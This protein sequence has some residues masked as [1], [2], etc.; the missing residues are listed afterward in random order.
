MAVRD[1]V[2]SSVERALERVLEAGYLRKWMVLGV[3]IGIVAGLG[4]VG[5][6]LAIRLC[7]WLL[8]DVVG[9]YVPPSAVGEG[10]GYAS[11]FARPW[12]VP[13]VVGFGG[14]IS[15]V[16]VT[17]FAPEA[18]GHGTDAAIDAVHRNPRGMRA[19][20]S[21]VKLVASAVTIGSGGSAGREGPTAQ[22]S[23][24]FASML[25]RRLDLT[26]TDAR[27]AVT[28]GIGS[29][30][31]AIF[32]APLGGA[33]LGAE[34]LYRD[35]LEA[36]AIFPSF[37][38]SV[39]GFAVFAAVEGFAPI[40]GYLEPGHFDR[41]EQLP[42]YAVIGVAAGLVARLYSRT[43]YGAT[44]G[45]RRLALP[46]WLKPALA[47]I[48]V[49][50]L[51]LLIPGVL[52]T[53]YGWL[54]RAMTAEGLSSMAVWI[55]IALPFAKIAA[56][57][58]TIG[59]GGSGGIFGPG[60]VIGG[61]VGATIWVIADGLAGVPSSPAPFVV[62]GMT[63][64]F[65]SIAHAPIAMIL[66][67][68]EMTGTLELILPA[69]VAIGLAT[70]VVGDRSIYEHQR[71][72]RRSSPGHRFRA[73]M[74]LLATVPV[75]TGMRAPA[76]VAR[77]GDRADGVRRRMRSDGS[78]D[79]VVVDGR[80]RFVGVVSI[81]AL[82]DGTVADAV[83]STAPSVPESATLED[84]VESFA[85]SDVTIVPVLDD[86]HRVIGVV[87]AAAAVQ[88]YRLALRANLEGLGAAPPGTTLIEAAVGEGSS[89][90]GRV[91]GPEVLP[92]GSVV[93]AIRRG[94][95]LLIAGGHDVVLAGDD[96]VML[97]PSGRRDEVRTLIEGE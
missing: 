3:A 25:A 75:T 12:A 84:A 36:E 71:K 82:T 2:G 10:S 49:G 93:V 64:C 61:F 9:G 14:L 79:A 81:D 88:A 35:D 28:A 50:L 55:V 96:V 68:A 11:D 54:Q 77:T 57:S 72:D 46:G 76:V 41:L 52:G 91:P 56:T 58:L 95:S 73:S 40:F 78:Q 70:L 53:G 97:V 31:G 67:V 80:A 21:F 85:G 1:R 47:G 87:T 29:G 16:L 63:A 15:G 44:G 92:P 27:I 83:D 43:F 6:T 20:A 30:I 45:F 42:Y 48:V 59:S 51:G 5:F 62:V 24:G 89:L 74:P 66:M 90:V 18:E 19:R 23:A 37:I 7:S 26:P 39:T 94:E 65:G 8:L 17:R 33:I 32:R 34:I 22:I 4:A 86:A 13:L 38:S 60:M 69:M